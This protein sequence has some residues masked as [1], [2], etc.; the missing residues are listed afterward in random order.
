MRQAVRRLFRP[1]P[2]SRPVVP[3]K[4]SG[5]GQRLAMASV[6]TA[7]NGANGKPNNWHGAGAAE[8]DMRSEFRYA[9]RY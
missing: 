7:S 2:G 1:L 6:S 4:G 3:W 9:C 8:F 5:Y